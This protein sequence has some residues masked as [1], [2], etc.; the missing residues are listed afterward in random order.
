[1]KAK[2][3]IAGAVLSIA[4]NASFAEV[5]SIQ[6]TNLTHGIHYTPLFFAAHSDS[7]DFFELGDTASDAVASMAEGG[8]TTL[9]IAEAEA[10]GIEFVNNPFGGIM[11]PGASVSID[12][13]DTLT[14]DKLSIMAMLLPTNDAF[15][16]LDSW[17]IPSEP[18]TYTVTLDAY[19]AGSEINDEIINGGGPL[20]VAGIPIA[21]GM[22]GGEGAT[23]LT[24]MET[25]TTIHVHR[26]VTGDT[27]P[28][29]GVSDLDSRIHR[30]LN[31]V[32]R[33]VVTVQ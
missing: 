3:L 11:P 24:D 22:D 16:G 21:P 7:E 1:M 27:N 18:G 12:N 25:N 6:F 9:L 26:G 31:P 23:G 28:T 10:L 15:V 33:I 5:I 14:N 13:W 32:A 29:G 4:A 2:S 8:A 30:W 17:T 19:D 20:G